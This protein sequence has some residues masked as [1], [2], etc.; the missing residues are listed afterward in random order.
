MSEDLTA[1]LSGAD[2]R[3]AGRLRAFVAGHG[4]AGEAVVEPIGRVGVRIVVVAAD[5]AYGDAVA[6]GAEAA[7]V[8]CERAAFP[9]PTGGPANS[10]PSSR[11]ARR[12]A[13]GWPAPAAERRA[14]SP[15]NSEDNADCR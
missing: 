7:A 12:T 8:I 1:G 10:P 15:K 4:G 13:G 6:S 3:H 14:T 2:A 5:G 11:R 9:L